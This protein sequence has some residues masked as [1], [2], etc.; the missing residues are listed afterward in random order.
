MTDSPNLMLAIVF[1]Y[2]GM[3]CSSWICLFQSPSEQQTQALMHEMAKMQEAL[4]ALTR[5]VHQQNRSDGGAHMHGHTE[6]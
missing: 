1:R 2:T 4:L 6:P 5:V 3:V